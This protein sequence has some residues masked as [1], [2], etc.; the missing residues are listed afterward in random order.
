MVLEDPLDEVLALLVL[1][2]QE[3]L[4]LDPDT[5]FLEL[6]PLAAGGTE[7]GTGS[8]A[9]PSRSRSCSG[10]PEILV[11]GGRTGARRRGC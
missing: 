11:P 3:E 2:D 1:V 4:L 6:S 10:S 8:Q 9:T 5:P 7:P